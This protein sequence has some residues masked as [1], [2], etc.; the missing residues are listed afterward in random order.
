MLSTEAS[1]L[2]VWF[3]DAHDSPVR[4]ARSLLP[5][6][7][8]EIE[9]SQAMI[10]AQPVPLWSSSKLR[11]TLRGLKSCTS[12]KNFCCEIQFLYQHNLL[13]H[14]F[15]KTGIAANGNQLLMVSRTLFHMFLCVTSL[16]LTTSKVD[17]VIGPILQMWELRHRER[18]IHLPKITHTTVMWPSRNSNPGRGQGVW[19]S[20]W[21]ELTLGLFIPEILSIIPLQINPNTPLFQIFSLS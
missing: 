10:L 4:S 9:A 2:C 3:H 19:V 15:N 7:D 14:I 20:V 17:T 12:S 11:S 1:V 8:E 13:F 18:L 21:T 6:A 16:T 5:F